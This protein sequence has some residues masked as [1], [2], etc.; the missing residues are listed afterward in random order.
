MKVCTCDICKRVDS[1]D[2]INIEH[3]KL[4]KEVYNWYESSWERLDICTDCL[5]EIRRKVK[6]GKEA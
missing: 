1:I 2:C 5:S 6:K 4:K 3:Y